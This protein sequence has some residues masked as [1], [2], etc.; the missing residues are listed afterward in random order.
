MCS[1]EST[2]YLLHRG[3]LSCDSIRPMHRTST[4]TNWACNLILAAVRPS[5]RVHRTCTQH[6]SDRR[7]GTAAATANRRQALRQRRHN[8]QRR[9]PAPSERSSYRNARGPE[10]RLA[11][12]AARLSGS[13]RQE[14]RRADLTERNAGGAGVNLAAGSCS[15]AQRDVGKPSRFRLER[16][17]SGRRR[18]PAKCVWGLHSTEGSNPSL[19]AISVEVC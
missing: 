12:G 4:S 5:T 17:P 9:L 6:C 18:T 13:G 7:P 1:Y 8:R 3:T 10:C 14:C 2:G 15:R 19:S 16:W 11:L